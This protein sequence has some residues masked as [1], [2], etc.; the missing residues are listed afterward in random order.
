M[1]ITTSLLSTLQKFPEDASAR[2]EAGAR[3]SC[4]KGVMTEWWNAVEPQSRI[5]GFA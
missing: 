5:A 2:P 3:G 1:R 4:R